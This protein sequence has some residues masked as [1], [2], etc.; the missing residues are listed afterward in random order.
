MPKNRIFICALKQ[1]LLKWAHAQKMHVH[2]LMKT[3]PMDYEIRRGQTKVNFIIG[4]L[5]FIALLALGVIRLY[6]YQ[7]E[8]HSDKE[9]VHRQNAAKLVS[10]YNAT[11]KQQEVTTPM[12]VQDIAKAM[13]A[14]GEGITSVN[15]I[16]AGKKQKTGIS[17]AT[18]QLS[19]R[20]IR[21]NP[22]GTLR[23]TDP[24][25]LAAANH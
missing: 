7:S 9:L 3:T 1:Y 20:Y 5:I 6:Q 22:D 11:V 24:D 23:L 19:L 4:G 21:Q 15:G 12:T 17:Y 2:H 18:L 14:E 25:H 16:P 10:L 8:P 13:S